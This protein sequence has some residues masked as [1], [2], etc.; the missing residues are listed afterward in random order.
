MSPAAPKPQ[1]EATP[2]KRVVGSVT[3]PSKGAGVSEA[4]VARE[5]TSPPRP[6]RR[7]VFADDDDDEDE[8]DPIMAAMLGR[9][10]PQQIG[11]TK[12][13]NSSASGTGVSNVRQAGASGWGAASPEASRAAGVGDRVG[14]EGGDEEAGLLAPAAAAG[15]QRPGLPHSSSSGA[16]ALEGMLGAIGGSVQL[17]ALKDRATAVWSATSGG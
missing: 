13:G 5:G 6:A 16:A 8:D 2:P 4:A 11:G 14:A 15:Q 10:P 17:D 9:P 12:A 7:S 3:P 1:A